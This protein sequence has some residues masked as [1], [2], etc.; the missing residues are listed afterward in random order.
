VKDLSKKIMRSNYENEVSFTLMMEIL[1][2]LE[3]QK[4]FF[5]ILKGLLKRVR[6]LL[7]I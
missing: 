2:S 1:F 5:E 3:S 6:L 4:L 7:Y